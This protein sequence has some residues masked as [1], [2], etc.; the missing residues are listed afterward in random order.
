MQFRTELGDDKRSVPRPFEHH[1]QRQPPKRTLRLR[2]KAPVPNPDIV[3]VNLKR[4]KD[5]FH[6]SSGRPINV[7]YRAPM[8]LSMFGLH[9]R[10]IAG[11]IWLNLEP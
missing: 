4:Q 6:A 5:T 8:G 1:M 7:K 9:D 3:N 11:S 10:T 2:R